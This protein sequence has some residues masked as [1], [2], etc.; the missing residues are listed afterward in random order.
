[1]QGASQC[2]SN[3]E[4]SA[5]RVQ[6]AY[7]FFFFKSELLHSAQSAST[8]SQ[9]S[10][11]KGNNLIQISPEHTKVT[12][13]KQFWKKK[14]ILVLCIYAMYFFI[15]AMPRVLSRYTLVPCKFKWSYLTCYSLTP[16]HLEF[17]SC[18]NCYLQLW[19]SHILT[20]L[21]LNYLTSWCWLHR[22]SHAS[23]YTFHTKFLVFL[24]YESSLGNLGY[25]T[26]WGLM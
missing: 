11:K 6:Y 20:W 19:K 2:F 1:M 5:R 7:S 21:V 10:F 18:H 15:L 4:N 24:T 14:T 16:S 3:T 13:I 26:G 23:I 17:L 8:S 22:K 25:L 9:H 12:Y